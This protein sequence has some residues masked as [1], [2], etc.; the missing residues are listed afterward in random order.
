M[1][2]DPLA[3]KRQRSVVI[4]T[5]TFQMK[6]STLR[7]A[8]YAQRLVR[9]QKGAPQAVEKDLFNR[10][11]LHREFLNNALGDKKTAINLELK[12][13]VSDIRAALIL[14]K[15]I[16]QRRL[17]E[18]SSTAARGSEERSRSEPLPKA[19]DWVSKNTWFNAVGFE[20]ETA[21]AQS[22]DRDIDLAGNNKQSDQYYDL[23][24]ARLRNVF[25]DLIVGDLNMEA[26]D[27]MTEEP[28]LDVFKPSVEIAAVLMAR[29]GAMSEE[30]LAMLDQVTT[31]EVAAPLMKLLPELAELI[32]AIEQQEAPADTRSSSEVSAPPEKA[33]LWWQ[34]NQ[35]YNAEGYKSETTAARAID[36]LL[37]I[38]GYEKT[39]DK[40][41]DVLSERLQKLFPELEVVK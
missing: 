32:A 20:L 25:P 10:Y 23:L 30:E 18:I 27:K 5:E 6:T 26:F 7:E 29:L 24:S 17:N 15:A 34:R 37:D 41:Y 2:R 8:Q 39:S 33:I 40:Y 31:P 38:E 35:W 28:K 4:S 1:S 19:L 11:N 3:A 13:V 22:I 36:I 16:Q 14:R 12:E 21:A 9:L